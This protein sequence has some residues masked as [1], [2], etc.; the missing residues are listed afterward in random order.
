MRNQTRRA[1]DL[2]Q[3]P[4]RELGLDELDLDSPPTDTED[5]LVAPMIPEDPEHDRVI[6]SED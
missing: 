4:E 2:D 5:G 1:L 3:E 6:D